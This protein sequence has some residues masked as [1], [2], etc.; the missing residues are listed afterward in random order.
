L[1]SAELKPVLRTSDGFCTDK[2]RTDWTPILDPPHNVVSY[3]HDIENVWLLMDA[4]RA[5]DLPQAPLVDLYRTLW[6]YSIKY[7]LDV[8]HGGLYY[9]GPFN[10]PATD[11]N[12]SWWVQAELLISALRMHQLTGDARYAE[13]FEQTWHFIDE[14]MTDH[15]HGGW[16]ATITPEASVTGDKANVWKCAYH[17]G[18]ALIEALKIL[19]R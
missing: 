2:Y 14:K 13:I 6:E 18:R 9:T 5:L 15:Q 4:R 10:A 16:Y 7:G 11:R 12:K 19:K 1:N 8:D 3:G 17:N